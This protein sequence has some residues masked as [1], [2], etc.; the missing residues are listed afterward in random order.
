MLKTTF[1][2]YFGCIFLPVL[3]FGQQWKY[4]PRMN[5]ERASFEVVKLSDGKF[6]VAGG[7]SQIDVHNRCEVFDPFSLT[8]TE[9][10]GMKSSRHAY[11]STIIK[12]GQVYVTGGLATRGKEMVSTSEI[13]DPIADIWE[14]TTP[15]L[16][17]REGSD[18]ILL[19]N[20]KV[21]VT[22]GDDAPYGNYH[23][24]CEIFDPVS[25][26]I[27][28]TDSIQNKQF[29]TNTYY[30]APRNSIIKISGHSRVAAF[31]ETEEYN[32]TTGKWSVIANSA[33]P[34]S[35]WQQQSLQLPDGR[36]IAVSGANGEKELSNL[37][38]E[39]NPATNS[40]RT[41][42]TLPLPRALG[43][44]VHISGDT[45]L[46]IGGVDLNYVG[47]RNT[48][49]IDVKNGT[50]WNGP[51][52]NEGRGF[53]RAVT[54][55]TTD[56][57]D[58]CKE[59]V[60]VYVFGGYTTYP[61]SLATCESITFTARKQIAL[62][63]PQSLSIYGLPCEGIDTLIS[64]RNTSCASITIDSVAAIGLEGTAVSVSSGTLASNDSST[65]RILTT[66]KKTATQ[67]GVVLVYYTTNGS[68][69]TQS[70]PLTLTTYGTQT[71]LV[72]PTSLSM[73]GSV[74][75]GIDTS[76]TISNVSCDE[77]IVD[78][79]TLHGFIGSTTLTQLPISIRRGDS[80]S[81]RIGFHDTAPLNANGIVEVFAHTTDTL[82]RKTI[83]I[84]IEL[85]SA[86]RGR[87][88]SV[89]GDKYDVGDSFE[90]PIYLNSNTGE[91][92]NGI[93]LT[94]DYDTD[95]LHPLAPDFESTL[96]EGT[97]LYDLNATPNGLSLYI[98]SSFILSNSKPLVTLRFLSYVSDTN[99]TL[100][101]IAGARFDPD[102]PNGQFCEYQILTDSAVICRANEC[103]DELL[104][105]QLRRLPLRI[106]G[107][108]Y[109]AQD[110][111]IR[112]GHTP[113]TSAATIRIYDQLGRLVRQAEASPMSA[114][115]NIDAPLPSGIYV[116]TL[117]SLTDI[118]RTKLLLVN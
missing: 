92:V 16:D 5:I 43:T 111:S 65:I 96:T 79:L 28:F 90:L 44:T 53:H 32:I 59:Y 84:S 86:I 74:C 60:T 14:Y 8:W 72:V 19:P 104:R 34:H 99:C 23:S 20:G 75:D 105:D 114:N 62:S 109:H 115:T 47:M 15:T 17:L 33:T 61:N 27:A 76:I 11:A 12:S 66:S 25:K 2:F 56:S 63:L 7:Y 52:L 9:V 55:R 58:L 49:F 30:Y 51:L 68:H 73:I 22:A 94:L 6:L 116:L 24:S 40:W 78:S 45:I 13:Y 97:A 113:I 100:L 39:F 107:V 29:A 102:N 37:V 89:I 54:V 77:L 108:S 93:E 31:T 57:E 98:P 35:C 21:L 48:T 10:S 41:V 106:T 82:I 101:R 118:A 85:K 71:D 64:I 70:I 83:P 4:I 18:A 81:I 67:S 112:V 26:Q 50:T 1:I 3:L 46:V 69:I 110:N 91:L 80:T 42:C 36:I 95:L 87:I 88:R 117:T 103:G 38:E